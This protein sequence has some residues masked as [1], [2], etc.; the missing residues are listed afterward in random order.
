MPGGGAVV[1][2]AVTVVMAGA[3]LDVRVPGDAVRHLV[4][5]GVLTSVV[6][7][8]VFRLVPVLEGRALRWP[9]L[10]RVALWGL[11]A[12]IVVRSAEVLV[13][14]GWASVASWIPLS[15]VLVWFAVACA[16]VNLMASIG[17]RPRGVAWSAQEGRR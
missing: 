12:G 4:T 14:L 1:G 9:R 8:M 10:R 6:V 17:A 13:G 5:I 16:G 11:A 3:G 2:S 7:A 15:G